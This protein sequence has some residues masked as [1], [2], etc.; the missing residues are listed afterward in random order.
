MNRND[1]ETKI[2]I[3]NARQQ[4]ALPVSAAAPSIAQDDEDLGSDGVTGGNA[5]AGDLLSFNGPDIPMPWSRA[6]M[7]S[8]SLPSSCRAVMPLRDIS[9]LSSL[10]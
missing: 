5:D 9:K 2:S 7:I 10:D 3:P 8:S 1:R 6:A 4:G